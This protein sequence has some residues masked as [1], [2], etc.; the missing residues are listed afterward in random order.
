MRVALQREDGR[1]LRNKNK[2][3]RQGGEFGEDPQ[4]LVSRPLPSRPALY[5]SQASLALCLQLLQKPLRHNH[6]NLSIQAAY[7]I[8]S[9][10]KSSY[11]SKNKSTATAY[12]HFGET[13]MSKSPQHEDIYN[14]LAAKDTNPEPL[15]KV[16][17]REQA[18]YDCLSCRV[19]GVYLLPYIP[20]FSESKC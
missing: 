18:D 13:A 19:M 14:R 9:T 8:N 7:Q 12:R 10:N 1:W 17:A 20:S 15:K 5:P 11:Q 3:P 4:G 16:L 2:R 6:H